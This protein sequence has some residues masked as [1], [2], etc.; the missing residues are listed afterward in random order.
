LASPVLLPLKKDN[1]KVAT[2][3]RA[4]NKSHT[5][6]IRWIIKKMFVKLN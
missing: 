2:A 1:L 4:A 6:C 3:Q 5:D